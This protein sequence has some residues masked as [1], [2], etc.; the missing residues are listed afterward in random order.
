MLA[1]LCLG[2]MAQDESETASLRNEIEEELTGNILPFWTR[3]AA[4]P[5]GG[6]YG[7]ITREGKGVHE[8]AKGAVLGSRELWTFSYAYRLY[9]KTEH[10]ALADRLQQY[11]IENFIDKTYGGVYWTLN[12]D[13]TPKETVKQT[14][15]LAYAIYGLAEHFRATGNVESLNQA[16]NLFCTLEEKVHDHDRGGYLELLE[17]DFTRAQKHGFVENMEAT[18]TMN[19]H[20]HVLEAYTTLYKVWRD[21]AL[22][23]CL[24]ELIGILETRLYDQKRSHLILFC[25]DDWNPLDEVDSYGHDI[26]TSWLLCE[27]AETLGDDTITN[28]IH[29]QAVRMVDVAISEGMGSDGSMIYEKNRRGVSR[30]R[31]WWPHCETVIG[32]INAWQITGDRKYFDQAVTTW[33]FIK[34]HFIDKEY[35]EWFR[36]VIPEAGAGGNSA[37]NAT[38]NTRLPKASLWNCPY[39]NSRMCYELKQR[40]N[41]H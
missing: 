8:A 23:E 22:R 7:V 24:R 10:K 20:I 4:D 5:Q 33:Q 27:A 2:A 17:R 37:G 16:I 21:D 26:E 39:H 34:N 28:R 31:Q 19:T 9:G 36:E 1:A 32:C 25:D 18:K 15:A 3:N 12:P 6:F 40:L 29:R 30:Q 14:Y 35:G 11:F 13:G 38:P 41:N